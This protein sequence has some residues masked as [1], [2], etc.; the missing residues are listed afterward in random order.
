[1][2]HSNK[3]TLRMQ[4][5]LKKGFVF[6]GRYILDHLLGKGGFSEVWLAA[7]AMAGNMEVAIKIYAPGNGLD[8]DGIKIFSNEYS[9]VFN[10][11]HANLLMPK[12]FDVWEDQPYLVMKYCSHGSAA[13]IKGNASVADLLNFI[14]D[15]TSAIDYLH[16]RTPPL[17]HQ[18][19]KPE[20]FIMDAG[21]HWLL[22]DF[23]ISKNIKRTLMHSLPQTSISAG[24][25]CYMAPERFSKNP[26]ATPASDIWSLGAT[27]FE[28]AT[29][30]LPFDS[31][32]GLYQKSGAEIPDIDANIGNSLKQ[33]I[34]Q[35]LSLNPEARFTA[36]ALH[37]VATKLLNEREIPSERPTVNFEE[38]A[39]LLIAHSNS[40]SE[41]EKFID[42]YPKGKYADNA[43]TAIQQIKEAEQA[44]LRAEEKAKI[45]VILNKG[46]IDDIK[47]YLLAHPN[48]SYKVVLDE[49]VEKLVWE[50]TIRLASLNATSSY[51]EQYPKGAH[52]NDARNLLI[53]LKDT[54]ENN[55]WETILNKED[56]QAY[57]NNYPDKR[58]KDE[59]N[60]KY[61]KI[62]KAMD[63][64]AWKNA[65]N[66]K[67]ISLARAYL[68]E[69][70]QG[71]YRDKAAELIHELIYQQHV[72]R[73]SSD[74]M[75]EFIRKF[76]GSVYIESASK[77]A[78]KFKQE[79]KK[80]L[81]T[82]YTIL[83]FIIGTALLIF[84]II[85]LSNNASKKSSSSDQMEDA[86]K[87]WVFSKYDFIYD[88]S[89]GR[90]VV[91][92]N[93]LYGYI[94]QDSVEVIPLQF[95]FAQDFE[96]GKAYVKKGSQYYF[97][98]KDGDLI[99]YTDEYGNRIE[100]R[101]EAV[102]VVN[103]NSTTT[104]NG[105]V[106]TSWRSQYEYVGAF[107]SNRAWVY[108]NKKWGLVNGNGN[109]IVPLQFDEVYEFSGGKAKVK[110]DGKEYYIDRDGNIVAQNVVS[111]TVSNNNSSSNNNT[112]KIGDTYAGGIV[113]YLDAT[114][115]HGLVCTASTHFRL[116]NI[117]AKDFCNNLVQGGY[118][119]WYLPSRDELNLMCLNLKEHDI[120]SGWYWSSTESAGRYWVVIF[121]S[122]E[123]ILISKHVKNNVR[124]IRAF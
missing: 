97:I 102:V 22:A 63:E 6:A 65:S 2:Q 103:N 76:P 84:I 27:L 40:Q 4:Q 77:Q 69:Y 64:L 86:E 57:I 31:M 54:I 88:Y 10:L 113:F 80:L 98:D 71:V 3:A 106:E 35:C 70:P 72:Y 8:Q 119:D 5:K 25:S 50:N 17:L 109:I 89:E 105:N 83:G 46:T 53:K 78:E 30:D 59:I 19:I 14:I 28:L 56:L 91:K 33:I 16:K 93:G 110:K 58:T 13:K 29:G 124:A 42:Q 122:G 1:M 52:I 18:D 94:D 75:N 44:Q 62:L 38:Q 60:I 101:S 49:K 23:G 81:K 37:I 111:T 11:N 68:N 112:L 99:Y 90:A 67:D 43:R 92:D 66:K 45:D 74:A 32:G 41:F 108:K 79:E 20:N 12:H 36:E 117:S 115:K 118:S 55:S 51:I 61:L 24:T 100:E 107:V 47:A 104:S 73:G 39:W 15:A 123:Q 34:E 116:D 26:H 96:N 85:L 114:G 95:S 21:G 48:T 9:L 7:D 87:E 120:L 121:N 82:I